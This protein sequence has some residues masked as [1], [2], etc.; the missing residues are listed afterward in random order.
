MTAG[1][2]RN[3]RSQDEY[4]HYVFSEAH[5]VPRADSFVW[6]DRMWVMGDGAGRLSRGGI[7]IGAPERWVYIR[8][9]DT[10]RFWSVPHLPVA[11]PAA[12]YEFVAGRDEL[13]W[14]STVADIETNVALVLPRDD[15]AELWSVT[16]RNAGSTPRAVSMVPFFGIGVTG[17]QRDVA[18]WDDEIGGM[19]HD[20][21]GWWNSLDEYERMDARPHLLLCAPDE[22][23]DG[24]EFSRD[25]FIGTGAVHCPEALSREPLGDGAGHQESIAAVFQFRRTLAGGEEFTVRILLAPARSRDEMHCLRG[26]YLAE[27]SDRQ[28][29][30][31]IQ[32]FTE[33]HTPPLTLRSPTN[34]FDS[35]MSVWLPRQMHLLGRT[36]RMM[37]IAQARNAI[38]DL[39]GLMYCDPERTRQCVRWIWGH[40][41]S[42]GFMPHGLP[43][44]EGIVLRGI[45]LSPHADLNVWGPIVLHDYLAETGCFEALEDEVGFA[46][47]RKRAPVYEHLCRGLEWL[48]AN[49]GPRGLALLG[50]GDW[51]DPLN[52]AGIEGRGESVWLTEAMAVA[53]DRWAAVAQTLGDGERAT[54][55]AAEAGACREVVGEL[56]WDGEWFARGTRDDGRWFGVADDTEGRIFL[57]AQSWALMAGAASP[58]RIDSVIE[59]VKRH[60]MT[61]AGP[62][63]LAP[64]YGGMRREIGKL[65]MKPAGTNENGSV[66]SHAA[67]FYAYALY[68]VRRPREAWD[69][70][71]SL[72]PGLTTNP[73]E[74]CAQLPLYLPN[75]FRG[76]GA[77]RSAG[78]SSHRFTTG[79][80]PWFYHTV[81]T[82]LLGIRPELDGLRIDPQLPPHW[83]EVAIHRTWR[84]AAYDIRIEATDGTPE[85][86]C[87]GRVVA[88]GVLPASEE[89]QRHEVVIRT[90]RSSKRDSRGE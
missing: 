71:S 1:R 34:T 4:E 21:F 83:Q 53:L 62:M 33:H 86:V 78:H 39:L 46:D 68:M 84:G 55:Y 36:M 29:R 14:R 56:A 44:R 28:V 76:S 60:L 16:V 67:V 59:A 41:K 2:R 47:V 32:A 23:P 74:R 9:D 20:W 88:D 90:R 48:L 24:W 73:I 18:V 6:N 10:M 85:L 80:A 35:L 19:V 70:L 22:H 64:P 61:P 43:L 37:D 87:D 89:G 57:N 30:D 15:I 42:D 26:K 72:V 54:R 63:M 79:C 52:L 12:R 13:G 3:D 65:T 81:A 69:V 8:D 25:A 5:A 31:A 75:F 17:K 11:R 51:N 40:Q 58:E 50:P 45:Y 27:G 7:S 49:R 77:G 66:Y 82:R 38:Q